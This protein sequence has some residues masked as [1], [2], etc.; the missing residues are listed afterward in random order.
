MKQTGLDI[1]FQKISILKSKPR[2]VNHTFLTI[3]WAVLIGYL[4]GFIAIH[5]YI[6]K[7]YKIKD[8]V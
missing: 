2:I 8:E 3:Y 4:V 7:L 1:A 5:K 6:V